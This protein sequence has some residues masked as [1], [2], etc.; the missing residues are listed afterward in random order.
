[1]NM[2]TL[3]LLASLLLTTC[4]MAQDLPYHEIPEA[5]ESYSANNVLSRMIDGLGYRYYWATKDLTDSDLEYKVSE[6]SRTTLET[7]EHT[8]QQDCELYHRER[9][10]RSM[11]SRLVRHAFHDAAGGFDG[12]VNVS[13]TKLS[14][15]H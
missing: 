15:C 11:G 10:P 13:V 2:R 7:M 6:S 14:P 12:V 3:Q 5:P 8:L 1:M 4:T 9:N